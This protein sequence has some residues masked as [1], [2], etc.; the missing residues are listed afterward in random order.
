VR[1]TWAR[2]ETAGRGRG[3]TRHWAVPPLLIAIMGGVVVAGYRYASVWT[4]LQRM[5]LPSYAWSAV[6]SLAFDN[7]SY[8]LLYV[9]NRNGRRFASDDDVRPELTATGEVP[10]A[11][12]EHAV[13]AGA[14]R[15][16]WVSGEFSQA[17]VYAQLRASIFREQSLLDLATPSFWGSLFAVAL[18][19]MVT[20]GRAAAAALARWHE[21]LPVLVTDPPTKLPA[22]VPGPTP[23]SLTLTPATP[24][25]GQS[26][27]SEHAPRPPSQAERPFFR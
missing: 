25:V 13:Q 27:A 22:S 18:A 10:F 23:P 3:R 24:E 26:T 12:S 20:L 16:T 8:R 15:L 2:T 19:V 21:R 11:L 17:G 6:A 7:G 9:V 14:Q 1:H 4:P 5:Y